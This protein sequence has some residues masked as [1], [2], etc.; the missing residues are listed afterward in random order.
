MCE[1]GEGRALW[2]K[3]SFSSV[4]LVVL[5]VLWVL[6]FSLFEEMY[7]LY[8]LCSSFMSNKVVFGK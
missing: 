8:P 6:T 7:V 1:V 2:V 3:R 4:F 5:S